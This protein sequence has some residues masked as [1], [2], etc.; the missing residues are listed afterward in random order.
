[1]H[2]LVTNCLLSNMDAIIRSQMSIC[3]SGKGSSFFYSSF[4]CVLKDA[5]CTAPL[6]LNLPFSHIRCIVGE[7][8]TCGGGEEVIELTYSCK[9]VLV[10]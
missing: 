2:V 7:S 5:F 10:L 3:I 1:M 6:M 8:V 9:K 4:L